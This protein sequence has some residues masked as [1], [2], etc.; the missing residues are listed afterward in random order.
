MKIM[1]LERKEEEKV[2]VAGQCC[3]MADSS[4]VVSGRP[5]FLPDFTSEWSARVYLAY[6]V[7]RLGKSVKERFAG[8]YYDACSLALRLI[9]RGR[10]F[11]NAQ[12]LAD[13]CLALSPF[14]TVEE[15]SDPVLTL[16]NL[17]FRHIPSQI[18]AAIGQIS[19]F[20]TIKNGDLILVGFQALDKEIKPRTDFIGRIGHCPFTLALR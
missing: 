13:N 16:D 4:M 7:S 11:D 18:A 1:V 19:R 6:R 17:S 15:E 10:E 14:V 8:R 3:L 12:W 9:P 20:A 5:L 2:D